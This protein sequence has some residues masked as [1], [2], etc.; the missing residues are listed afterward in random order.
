M[1]KEY[2]LPNGRK[3][4]AYFDEK[5]IAEITIQAIDSLVSELNYYAEGLQLALDKLEEYERGEEKDDNARE[6]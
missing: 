6:D 3:M 5:G 1:L 4:V 2:G